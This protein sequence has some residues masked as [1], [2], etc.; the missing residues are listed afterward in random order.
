M[1]TRLIRFKGNRTLKFC[2]KFW[3]EKS[4]LCH[5]K[6]FKKF[7]TKITMT[8]F[9]LNYHDFHD[10][11]FSITQTCFSGPIVYKHLYSYFFYPDS[12]LARLLSP[13]PT[14]HDKQGSTI[15]SAIIIH[16]FPSQYFSSTANSQSEITYNVVLYCILHIVHWMQ[17]EMKAVIK[18]W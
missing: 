4:N 2:H 5:T 7:M 12:Q 6:I 1:R 8:L 14:S 13:V 17:T 10:L 15:I 11:D 16:K 3:N 18:S 9:H